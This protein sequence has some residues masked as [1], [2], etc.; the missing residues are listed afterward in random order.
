MTDNTCK[1]TEEKKK[2][3]ETNTFDKLTEEG[4]REFFSHLNNG[5]EVNEDICDMD[6][7]NLTQDS[8]KYQF[9]LQCERGVFS[10]YFKV[11]KKITDVDYGFLEIK[12]FDSFKTAENKQK[13]LSDMQANTKETETLIK[14]LQEEIKDQLDTCFGKFRTKLEE[15]L[16]R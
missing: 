16:A 8:K 14:K 13:Y 3:L 2:W 1:Q 11:I 5:K 12:Y 15:E 6:P 7:K 9:W 4:Q 10:K